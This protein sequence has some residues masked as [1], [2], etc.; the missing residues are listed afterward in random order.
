[1]SKRLV[2]C[3]DGTWNTADQA[4]PTN[5]TKLALGLAGKSADGK[6]QRVFYHR[7]VG[8]GRRDRIGG[9]AFGIGLS[10]HVQETYRFL[11][12]NYEPGDEIFL[13]GF[14]RGAFTARSTAGFI[15][16]SGILHRRFENRIPQAY[17]LYRDRTTH[18]RGTEAQLFRRTYSLESRIRCIG[19]WDTVGA[20]GVPLTGLPLVDAVNKR[21]QFHDTTLSTTVD[22][23]FHALAID[24]KRRPFEP[25][26]WQQQ[27]DAGD[28][29]L[30]QVWFAGVHSD[31]GGGYPEGG[32]ADIALLWMVDRAE[33]CG[34]AF[35]PDAFPAVAPQDAHEDVLPVRPDPMGK[36]HGSRTGL[37]LLQSPLHRPI[38]EKDPAHERV[39]S[40]AKQRYDDDPAYRPEQLTAYLDGGPGVTPIPG[41]RQPA[42]AAKGVDA[43]A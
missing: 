14:S 21:W 10:A 4:C 37:Y 35:R 34:L 29:R 33:S 43:P 23:A 15:R 42:E 32:L 38:G 39:A 8:T 2:M 17:A 13:F 36:L 19:V 22:N 40:T 41:P 28:Q 1:M 26:L 24:E 25:T 16:N 27:S 18:P 20:L 12:E 11:V 6:E 30:E 3:C 9:G 5:V 7:G 31:V